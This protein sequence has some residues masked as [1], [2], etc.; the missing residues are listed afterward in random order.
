MVC[1]LVGQVALPY[2]QRIAMH[3][4]KGDPW[5]TAYHVSG[6]V[7]REPILFSRHHRKGRQPLVVAH[8]H[9]LAALY[10][11]DG[12][13]RVAAAAAEYARF[14]VRE[15]VRFRREAIRPRIGPGSASLGRVLGSFRGFVRAAER[16]LRPIVEAGILSAPALDPEGEAALASLTEMLGLA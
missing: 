7:S 5:G 16:R 13:E 6:R 8:Y 3:R 11:R 12:R 1:R 10:E 15:E 4:E 9:R 2:S 14:R